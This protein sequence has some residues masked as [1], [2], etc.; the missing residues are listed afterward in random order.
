MQQLGIAWEPPTDPIF[1]FSEKSAGPT[2]GNA[3]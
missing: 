2:A 3:S 1:G